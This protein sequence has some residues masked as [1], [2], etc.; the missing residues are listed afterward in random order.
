MARATPPCPMQALLGLLTGPWTTYI[1][2]VLGTQG[3]TRF[4]ALRRAVPG[5]SARLLTVR[6]RVL[7]ENGV[8]ARRVDPTTPPQ[9]SYALTARGLEL[10]DALE[11]LNEVAR[12]WYQA[13]GNHRRLTVGAGQIASQL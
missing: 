8:I 4:G 7:E 13:L 12:R 9:V 5:I 3:E 1:L 2:W 10:M 6:L 11:S